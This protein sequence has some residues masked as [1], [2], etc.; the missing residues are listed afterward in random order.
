MLNATFYS[1][2]VMGIS[3]DLKKKIGNH[4]KIL[5]TRR[6]TLSEFH[7]EDQKIL[8]AILQILVPMA[9]W[10]R[11]LCTPDHGIYCWILNKSFFGIWSSEIGSNENYEGKSL[12]NRKCLLVITFLQEYLQKLFVSYFST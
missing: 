1:D 3:I 6:S 10:R 4:F 7:T 5:G 12:N 11:D 8:V 9:T 2:T